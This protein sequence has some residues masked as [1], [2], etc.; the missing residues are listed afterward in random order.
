MRR[1]LPITN[2]LLI[3][4]LFLLLGWGGYSWFQPNLS[5]TVKADEIVP[6][7]RELEVSA[8]TRQVYS[9][10]VAEDVTRLNLFRKERK[11]Y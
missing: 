6:S 11:Q 2:F 9:N 3:L 8:L 5:S 4:I 7:N 1:K 10:T